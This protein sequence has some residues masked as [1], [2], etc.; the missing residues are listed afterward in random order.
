[1]G[2]AVATLFQAIPVTAN[3]LLRRHCRESPPRHNGVSRQLAV[4]CPALPCSA[5]EPRRGLEAF[6]GAADSSRGSSSDSSSPSRYPPTLPVGGQRG[7][8]MHYCTAHRLCHPDTV[9]LLA[10][11]ERLAQ[12]FGRFALVWLVV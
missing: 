7:A 1:M 12:I 6:Q 10:D 9:C 2:S 4:P 11:V 8:A 3:G 5:F